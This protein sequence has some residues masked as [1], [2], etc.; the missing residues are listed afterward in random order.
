M[1]KYPLLA[2]CKKGDFE[3]V[4]TLDCSN[5]QTIYKGNNALDMASSKGYID[6]VDYLIKNGL[7]FTKE[8]I[9][10]ALTK[11]I[12]NENV[13]VVDYFI[14]YS[15][16]IDNKETP[17]L[18]TAINVENIDII[19]R[20]IN[21]NIDL[22]LNM[23]LF[24]NAII[25]G[26]LDIVMR[27]VIRGCNINWQDNDGYTPLLL[28][29]LY[30]QLDIAY[31][32]LGLGCNVNLTDNQGKNA[33]FYIDTAFQWRNSNITK[34][35]QK[36]INTLIDK[37]CD[38]NAQTMY[39]NTPLSHNVTDC[40]F[41]EE[42][43]KTPSLNS[44]NV[45]NRKGN[46]SLIDLIKYNYKN[47]YKKNI[48]LFVVNGININIANKRGKTALMYAVEKGN[49]KVVELL[50]KNGADISMKDNKGKSALSY[51][52]QIIKRYLLKKIKSLN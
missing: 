32:F 42:I 8:E 50:V 36:L 19:D 3:F 22:V 12:A 41:I 34:E 46:T 4:K 38:V 26:Q 13:D 15:I 31:F 27:L 52:D 5:K 16:I 11:A 20:L 25:N 28:S 48:E 33:L 45:V 17:L 24:G 23:N 6:I 29:L 39:A 43:F 47:I 18:E 44:I 30:G 51:A 49:M 21:S 37:G 1:A 35:K 2:A 40:I 9:H 14:K 7:S 10:S